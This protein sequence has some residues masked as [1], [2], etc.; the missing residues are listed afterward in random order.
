MPAREKPHHQVKVHSTITDIHTTT[1][2]PRGARRTT[3][4]PRILALPRP[5]LRT[6]QHIPTA[7][8]RKTRPLS[9]RTKARPRLAPIRRAGSYS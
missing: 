9:L 6:H 1:T 8:A 7:P 2:T 5:L 4:P 3:P